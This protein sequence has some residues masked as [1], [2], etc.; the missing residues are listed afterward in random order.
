MITTIVLLALLVLGICLI[1]TDDFNILGLIIAFIVSF[2]LL[3]H[4]PFILMVEYDYELFVEKRNAFEETLKDARE[5]GSDIERA[6]IIQ[7]VSDW[8]VKLAA[9]K[10][11]NTTWLLD[12][13]IDDRVMELEPIK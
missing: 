9:A 1:T 8:N 2:I 5:N 6:A 3:F 7:N 12:Q 10:Y 4:V 11:D 13:Y